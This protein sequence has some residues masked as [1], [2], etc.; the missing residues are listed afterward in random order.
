MKKI[1]VIMVLFAA[2]TTGLTAQ[3]LKPVKWQITQKK[4]SDG[5]YD[6]IC[7]ATVDA[8]GIYTTRNFPKADLCQP[9]SIWMKM[10]P[11]VSNW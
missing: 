2:F 11:A 3:V 5:V 1:L 6:I 10:K 9:P 7:K 8:D 4:V